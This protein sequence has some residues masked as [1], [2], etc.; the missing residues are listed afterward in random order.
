MKATMT[1]GH[2]AAP[3]AVNHGSGTQTMRAWP[4]AM[5]ERKEPMTMP[6]TSIHC[7]SMLGGVLLKNSLSS[8]LSP[9]KSLSSIP[10]V[11]T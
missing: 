6:R 1:R 7:Q 8:T 9:R 5:A 3:K 11:L 10:A 2:V 4:A